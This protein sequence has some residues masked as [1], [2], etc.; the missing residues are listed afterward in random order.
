[1]LV[2]SDDS[3][4]NQQE[5][6]MRSTHPVTP[7]SLASSLPAAFIVTAAAPS[8][9]LG[10][11]S[12]S[13]MEDIYVVRSVREERNIPDPF[14]CTPERVGFTPFAATFDRFSFWSIIVRPADSLV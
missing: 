9:A 6:V 7:A 13:A 12:T 3:E 8:D 11:T 10:V 1:M 14:F 5:V 2:S 4:A